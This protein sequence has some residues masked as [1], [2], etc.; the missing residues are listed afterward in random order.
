MKNI[1][2]YFF[3]AKQTLPAH[4]DSFAFLQS[5]HSIAYLRFFGQLAKRSDAGASNVDEDKEE[6]VA[7]V[8]CDGVVGGHAHE[9]GE[10]HELTNHKLGLVVQV[11]ALELGVA[12]Q[13]QPAVA[14]AF[15]RKSGE[16]HEL[17]HGEEQQLDVG[18]VKAER[19]LTATLIQQKRVRFKAK[20]RRT[21]AGGRPC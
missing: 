5:A 8:V 2:D 1:T 19:L 7:E 11:L 16:G 9:G 17:L 18:R 15:V 13:L 3:D 6:E 12:V 4:V 14:H 21:C 20:T 10:G